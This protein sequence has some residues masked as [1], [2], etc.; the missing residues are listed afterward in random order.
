[1]LTPDA[2]KALFHAAEPFNK[3]LARAKPNEKPGWEAFAAKV[4][5]TPAQTALIGTFTRRMPVLVVSGTWCGDCVQQCPII[6]AIACANPLIETRYLERDA[7]LQAIEGLKICGGNRVP[8]CVWLNE[9]F[10]FVHMLGDRTLA[11]YRANAAKQL[12]PSCPLPGA[13]VPPDELAATIAD[14]VEEFERVALLLRLS[15]KLRQRHGD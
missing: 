6:E 4:H 3:Y 8:V 7:H 11:R 10:E 9:D 14:W 13:P 12:G 5:L 2:F 1:M 15:A